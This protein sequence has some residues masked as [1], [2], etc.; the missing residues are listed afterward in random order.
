MTATEHMRG[1]WED[2]YDDPT[3]PIPAL[4]ALDVHGV[5]IGDGSDL[6]IVI[7][8]PMKADEYSQRRLLSKIENY[9]GFISS[10]AYREEFGAPTAENTAVVIHIH[11]SSESAIF[12][13]IERCK[14]WV[15]DNHA[16]LRVELLAG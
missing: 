15:L 4:A 2:N 3:H 7:A 11:R 13:L 14:P 5:K 10:P 6:G 12:E 9:L 1:K 8:S 16:T